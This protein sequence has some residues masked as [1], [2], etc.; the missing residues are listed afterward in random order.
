M[1]G[2]AVIQGKAS[3]GGNDLLAAS[4]PKERDYVQQHGERVTITQDEILGEPGER[5]RHVH[6]PLEGFIALL[7]SVEGHDALAVGLVGSE[8]MLGAPLVLGVHTSPLRARV[9]GSGSALRIKAAEFQRVLLEAPLLE[10]GLRRYLGTR[11]VQ[12]AQTAA[13]ASFHVVEARLACWLLMAHD[14]AHGDRFYLTHDRL[15][16]L[17]GVRRSGVSTAAGVLQHRKLVRYTRGHIQ[18]LD[19]PGLEQTACGCYRLTC[20]AVHPLAA[21]RR[22]DPPIPVLEAL[23]PTPAVGP[24]APILGASAP[25]PAAGNASLV[26]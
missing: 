11:L 4:S 20:D 5:I 12:L 1:V 23:P 15:A 25:T 26:R 2:A 9:Q 8:G 21:A 17:L 24:Q 7:A 18:V 10:R 16:R 6:F 13:C 22:E 3:P 14:R 19:R